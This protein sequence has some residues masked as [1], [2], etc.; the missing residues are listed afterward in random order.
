MKFSCAA[1]TESGAGPDTR[2]VVGML[3]ADGALAGA[4]DRST[5][6]G[7]VASREPPDVGAVASRGAT[8]VGAVASREPPDVGAVSLAVDVAFMAGAVTSAVRAAAGPASATPQTSAPARAIV[9]SPA[10]AIA[11]IFAQLAPRRDSVHDPMHRPRMPLLTALLLPACGDPGAPAGATAATTSSD[12]TEASSTST[13]SST[14]TT[15]TTP[16]T[17]TTSTADTTDATTADPTT[18]TSTTTSTTADL[19]TATSS[20]GE[21]ALPVELRA[22]FINVGNA[23]PQFNCFEYKLCRPQ[24]AASVRAYIAAWKPDVIALSEVLRADQLQ[25]AT[26]GGPILPPGYAGVCGESRDRAS[27]EPAAW[28]ADDASHEHECVAWNTARVE[29]VPGGTRSVYGAEGC[30]YDF[31]G[32]AAD[33]RL[34]GAHALTVVAVHPDSQEAGCRVQE[35]AR[36]W[37]ELAQGERV[38][39]GGDWNSDSDDE[40]QRP[41]GFSV[42]YLRGAHWD[43][44]THDDEWSAEYAFGLQKKKFDHSFTNF[45]APLTADLAFGSALGGY[46]DHPRADGGDGLDHRQQLVDLTFTP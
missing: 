11:R 22:L 44:A 39:I 13:S 3:A 21:P 29:L 34:D 36:Y 1:Y 24:D 35:I 41:P 20:T 32:F 5:D 43:L 45:G 28:D 4:F 30:N 9:V 42:A 16:T 46:D 10:L 33:L 37:S 7:D 25:S 38:L 18:T 26:G 2:G 17:P 12:S 31:T 15:P 23:S 40:L 8:D 19:T 6:V 14:S 27:G